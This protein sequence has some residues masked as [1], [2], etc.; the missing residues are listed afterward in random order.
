[1][2]DSNLADKHHIHEETKSVVGLVANALNQQSIE[3]NEQDKY[4]N[5]IDQD[6]SLRNHIHP[7]K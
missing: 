4:N 2:D 7:L 6:N 1:M 5:K 3:R